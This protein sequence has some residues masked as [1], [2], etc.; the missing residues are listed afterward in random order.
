VCARDTRTNLRLFLLLLVSLLRP[1]PASPATSHPL[2]QRQKAQW[3]DDP[4]IQQVPRTI[5]RSPIEPIII[6]EFIHL[7]PS[8]RRRRTRHR[9][10]HH[11]ESLCAVGRRAARSP[12]TPNLSHTLLSF[13][14]RSLFLVRGPINSPFPLLPGRE[15]LREC[16]WVFY[17]AK[18]IP[19]RVRAL[20]RAGEGD[21]E[22]RFSRRSGRGE[23]MAKR[24][25]RSSTRWRG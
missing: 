12:S 2:S 22:L 23:G 6:P 24:R 13:P 9:Q 5:P 18:R 21:G 15:G 4:Y 3:L 8:R 11:P 14:F 20:A 19:S 1:L 17:A 10:R 25:G 7:D 16:C